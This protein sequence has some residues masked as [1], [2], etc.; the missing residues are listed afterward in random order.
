MAI[1]ENVDGKPVTVS[2]GKAVEAVKGVTEGSMSSNVSRMSAEIH[3]HDAQGREL[4]TSRTETRDAQ[5]HLSSVETEKVQGKYWTDVKSMA[6]DATGHKTES[7]SRITE[8]PLKDG[9][10]ERMTLSVSQPTDQHGRGGADL[11]MALEEAALGARP[12]HPGQPTGVTIAESRE[13]ISRGADG[14][15]RTERMTDTFDTM[16]RET[17]GLDLSSTSTSLHADGKRET[18]TSTVHQDDH[19]NETASVTR[20][21]AS[22]SGAGGPQFA[23]V[24]TESMGRHDDSMEGKWINVRQAHVVGDSV[25]RLGG[26]QAVHDTFSAPGQ[27][28]SVPKT[29]A[30]DLEQG[31]ASNSRAL[32]GQSPGKSWSFGGAESAG[33]VGIAGLPSHTS[34]S[35]VGYLQQKFDYAAHE[36]KALVGSISE[37]LHSMLGDHT[38]GSGGQ[39]QFHKTGD[40]VVSV[41]SGHDASHG[42]PSTASVSMDR[43]KEVHE[44]GRV[45]SLDGDRM[46]A[47]ATRDFQIEN[48]GLTR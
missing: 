5:G 46:I 29:S 16:G 24:Q 20:E 39:L 19:G 12:T 48:R 9:S 15:T 38:A 2:T 17:R 26:S 21:G 22:V 6:T 32:P 13:H 18:V 31:G 4:S 14:S 3:G 11:R 1:F 47:S 23:Q 28:M 35:L 42:D 10:L 45:Q 7:L 25:A 34:D 36:A 37:Q 44:S 27:M 43:L 41:V 8:V 33:G 40:A 30:Q